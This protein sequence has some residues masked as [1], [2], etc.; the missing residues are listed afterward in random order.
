MEL[1]GVVCPLAFTA[2]TL[3]MHRRALCSKAAYCSRLFVRAAKLAASQR[4]G[5][6]CGSDATT[7]GRLH[8]RRIRYISI[9]LPSV[10]KYFL[11]PIKNQF[12]IKYDTF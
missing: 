2:S 1:V 11:H 7:P 12:N 3:L 5:Q 4:A 6:S 8:R 9:L 10:S